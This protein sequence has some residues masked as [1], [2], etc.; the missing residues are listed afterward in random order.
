[1]VS[2]QTGAH[3]SPSVAGE[4]RATGEGVEVTDRATGDV[5]ATVETADD[6]TLSDAVESASAVMPTLRETPALRRAEWCEAIATGVR[7]RRAE[8]AESVVRESG[9]PIASARTEVES[10]AEQFDRVAGELR[11]LTG[12]YRTWTTVE[13]TGDN[14]LVRAAPLGVVRCRPAA[15]A[16]LATAALQVAPAI[17]AGNSVL[18]NPPTTASVTVSKLAEIVDP[19]L[20]AGA[21]SFVPS[22]Y[23][24]AKGSETATNDVAA[25]I[26]SRSTA[27]PGA[28][29]HPGV[30]RFDLQLG[31]TATALVFPDADLDAAAATIAGDGP[32]GVDR[33]LAGASHVLVHDSV[34]AELVDRIAEELA[35]WT[36]GDLFDEATSVAP[37]R[38]EEHVQRLTSRLRDAVARGAELVRGGEADGLT[39]EPTL[40]SDVPADAALRREE[41]LGPVVPVTAFGSQSDA[42]RIADSTGP[43]LA[44]TVFTDSHSRA[45]DVA[46]AI[47]AGTVR[48]H[49]P[50]A[51]GA[52]SVERDRL[53]GIG[54]QGVQ[55]S[56]TRLT[57]TKRVVQR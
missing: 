1:M 31:G 4:S 52:V 11:S 13:R 24:V 50:D 36:A 10:A 30:T 53:G 54:G 28:T 29:G 56:I 9:T 26:D 39:V 21:C 37:L 48:V 55:E 41:Q 17:A 33:R 51:A 8:L 27:A 46:A 14:S 3:V 44:A 42:L 45:M 20:P 40:V 25:V 19:H 47:D 32:S 23:V 18:L 22:V 16:P 15:R 2:E 7:E 57:R 43:A 34:R 35:S 38:D 12:E 49:G 5:L 6:G